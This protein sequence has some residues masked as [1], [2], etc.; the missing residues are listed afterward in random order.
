[1]IKFKIL[2]FEDN[3]MLSNMY[4]VAFT[5]QGFEYKNYE[6]PPENAEELAGLVLV[7]KPSLIIMDILMPVMDGIQATKYLK[8]DNMT[9]DIPIIGLSNLGDQDIIDE[10]R[11]YGI[12]DYF[13]NN[14]LTPTELAKKIREMFIKVDGV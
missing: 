9:K 8:E 13:V 12:D 4:Q 3:E 10:L 11:S 6:H 1:M 7:E 2:H 5:K 14:S